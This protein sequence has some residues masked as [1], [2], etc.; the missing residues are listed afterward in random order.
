MA[1]RQFVAKQLHNA[2]VSVENDKSREKLNKAVIAARIAVAQ[3]IMPKLQV[4]QCMSQVN[5][6]FLSIVKS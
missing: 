1:I 4:S 3:A 6:T 5:T 2:A